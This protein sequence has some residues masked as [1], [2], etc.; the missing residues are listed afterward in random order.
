MNKNQRQKAK[1]KRQRMRRKQKL[2]QKRREKQQTCTSVRFYFCKYCNLVTFVA[3][4]RLERHVSKSHPDELQDYSF[5]R[6]FRHCSKVYCLDC[7]VYYNP[8][9]LDDRHSD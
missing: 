6:D 4:D 7:S 2:K 3:L 5:R 9:C 8:N 1:A